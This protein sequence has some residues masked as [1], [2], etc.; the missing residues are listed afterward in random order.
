MRSNLIL[1]LLNWYWRL[2]EKVKRGGN[3]W[4]K[5]Q[6]MNRSNVMQF[7]RMDLLHSPRMVDMVLVRNER[8]NVREI[9]NKRKRFHSL[10]IVDLHRPGCLWLVKRNGEDERCEVS[11]LW[12]H[13]GALSNDSATKRR[14]KRCCVTWWLHFLWIPCPSSLYRLQLW[15]TV[16]SKNDSKFGTFFWSTSNPYLNRAGFVTTFGNLFCSLCLWDTHVLCEISQDRE[17]HNNPIEWVLPC[18]RKS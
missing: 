15:F 5:V 9:W 18:K 12:I 14:S 13:C 7:F 2:D 16:E 1:N 4:L 3:L 6:L 17:L 11:V 8:R 10:Q